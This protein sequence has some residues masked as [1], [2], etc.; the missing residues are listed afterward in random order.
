V[1]TNPTHL[2][3]KVADP[4]SLTEA[5]G[6]VDRE[7][8]GD[9]DADCVT[10]GENDGDAPKDHE[11]EGERD[12]EAEG[13]NEADCVTLLVTLGEKDCDAPKDHE[14]EGEG[15]FE[16]EGDTVGENDGD[17]PVDHEGEGDGLK[18]VAA[19]HGDEDETRQESRDA[20]A[21]RRHTACKHAQGLSLCIHVH[22]K[23][24]H[25]KAHAVAR[26]H[27]R[28]HAHASPSRSTHAHIHFTVL[29]HRQRMHIAEHA[30]TTHQRGLPRWREMNRKTELTF[31]RRTLF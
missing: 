3:D 13:D 30:H 18:L 10:V 16:A 28:V 21:V 24:R 27:T 2:A 11:G 19:T 31:S 26:P 20:T 25:T 6:E 22:S 15:D 5:V 17:A 1:C 12:R 4:V 29:V 7:A 8:E 23:H 14:G 9:N